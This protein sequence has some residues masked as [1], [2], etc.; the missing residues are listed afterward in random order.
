MYALMFIGKIVG[1]H[2]Y[3]GER[4]NLDRVEKYQRFEYVL[5]L[6]G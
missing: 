6:L 1:T 3:I 2:K 4:H 5:C